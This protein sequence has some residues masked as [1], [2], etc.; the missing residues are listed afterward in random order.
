MIGKMLGSISFSDAKPSLILILIQQLESLHARACIRSCVEFF[1]SRREKRRC[2]VLFF[3][4]QRC[5][6]FR[7]SLPL[8]LPAPRGL[9][10]FDW[11]GGIPRQSPKLSNH[12]WCKKRGGSRRISPAFWKVIESWKGS[13]RYHHFP[14]LLDSSIARLSAFALAFIR[15]IYSGSESFPPSIKY[16]QVPTVRSKYSRYEL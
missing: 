5:H 16:D 2:L 15:S 3:P 7:W 12:S 4:C 10:W 11:M 8:V 6:L 9:A 14:S 1:P 13:S